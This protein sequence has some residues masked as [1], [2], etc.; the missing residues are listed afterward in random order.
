MSERERMARAL[1]HTL[2]RADAADADM[3][4]LCEEARRL[5]LRAVCVNPHWVPRCRQLLAGSPVVVCTVVGFPLG[6]ALAEVKVY[7]AMHARLRGAEELDIVMNVGAAR[8]GRWDF[9]ER[10]LAAV[11]TASPGLVQK[12][13]LECACLDEE[14]KLRAVEAARRAGAVFVKTSTGFGPGGAT[15]EDVRLL[16]RA[17]GTGMG[18]KAAGGIRTL[19]EARAM[20]QAGAARIGTSSAADIME[21]LGG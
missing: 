8:D 6:A 3:A 13:I 19:D 10:E 12:V 20:L 17:A 4:R 7:E 2:L 18:V 1:E 5:A 16:A 14:Q 9:V 11:V 15:V 21:E